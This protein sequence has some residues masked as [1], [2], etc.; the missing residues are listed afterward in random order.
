MSTPYN[1]EEAKAKLP[2]AIEEVSQLISTTIP[3]YQ[4]RIRECAKDVGAQQVIDDGEALC[5]TLDG[6]IDLLKQILG[7]EGDS[8]Q[9]ASLH[10]E[11]ASAKKMDSALNGI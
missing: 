11:L 5:T 1:L 3:G 4:D 6:L 7:E 2:A 8:V 10:G 9:T